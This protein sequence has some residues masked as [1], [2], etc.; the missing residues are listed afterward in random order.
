MVHDKAASGSA[1][2]DRWRRA[3]RV[4]VAAAG[5]A[6]IVGSGGGSL[7]FPDM[8]FTCGIG[9]GPVPPTVVLSPRRLAVQV[10]AAVTFTA[11]VYPG[12]GGEPSLQWC[13]QDKGT[14]TCTDIPGA[15]ARTYTLTAANLA[16]D[17]AMFQLTATSSDGSAHSQGTLTVS[18]VPG[19]VVQEGEFVEADWVVTAV[20]TP[21]QNG[22]AFGVARAASGGIPGAF[23]AMSYVFDAPRGS[24]RLYHESLPSTYDP[25]TLGAI[26]ALDFSFNCVKLSASATGL[27]ADVIPMIR[28]GGRRFIANFQGWDWRTL[29]VS[30]SWSDSLVVAGLRS[31]DFTL[32]DGPACG[33][34]EVCPDFSAQGE[35]MR[36]GLST[37]VDATSASS[38]GTIAQGIDNWKL[39]IWRR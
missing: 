10:G 7:G 14:D 4:A 39:T 22:P 30:S 15:T 12:T 34:G 26:S 11:N 3:A 31:D 20:V 9:N 8:C 32:A 33:P 18:S 24:V 13:R 29:C 2:P 27:F 28:Q 37:G 36:M 1:R 38:A 5:L 25:A 17:G 19:L 21:A 6:A 35:P 23:L 16:D